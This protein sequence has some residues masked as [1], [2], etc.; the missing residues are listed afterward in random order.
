MPT[1]TTGVSAPPAT[2]RV[3]IKELSEAIFK[4]IEALRDVPDRAVALRLRRATQS[5]CGVVETFIDDSNQ[6]EEVSQQ[7]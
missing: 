4:D 5:S 1:I 2:G 6:Q 7:N 3:A